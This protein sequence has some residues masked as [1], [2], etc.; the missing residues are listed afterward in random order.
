MKRGLFILIFSCAVIYTYAQEKIIFD[1]IPATHRA[2]DDRV[3]EMKIPLD[4]DDT[5]S[6]DK[7]NLIDETG[8][9]FPPLPTYSANLD[10][11]KQLKFQEI[12]TTTRFSNVISPFLNTGYVFNQ[13]IYKVSNRFSFGGNS[14]G[15]QSIFD[16]PKLNS[17][18]Q[19]M[20]VKG[21]SLF[22]QYKV[23]NAFKIETRVSVTNYRSPF[24]N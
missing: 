18:I 20:N 22:M 23:S 14:F 9:H 21:A 15:A 1:S 13:A 10:F 5:L 16:Q 24:G 7:I 8:L 3:P 12:S 11:L 2:F 17:S 6:T 4:F 19:E